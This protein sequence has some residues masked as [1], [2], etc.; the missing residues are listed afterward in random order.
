MARDIKGNKKSFC[1]YIGDKRKARKNVVPLRKET[2]DLVTWDIPKSEVLTDFLASV[3]TG[4]CSSHTSQVAD[5]KSKDW[6]NEEMP[7]VGE[8][9]VQDHLRNLKVHKSTGPGEVPA[10]VCPKGTG[11]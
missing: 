4:K 10:S 2:G 1:S 11:G 8:D 9:L 3:F 6:E 7:T 5:V